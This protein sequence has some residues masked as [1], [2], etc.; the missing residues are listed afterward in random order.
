MIARPLALSLAMVAALAA[1]NR[2]PEPDAVHAPELPARAITIFTPKTELFAEHEALV[3]GQESRFATH[4]TDLR[5]WSAVKAGHV[6]AVLTAPDGREEVFSVDAPARAGIFQPV[7]KPQAAGEYRLRFR[8]NAPGLTDAIDA[9]PATVYADAQAA[10]AAAPEEAEDPNEIS[11]LKEQQ[12]KIPFMTRPVAEG[13]LDAGVTL[14]GSV[15]P[16][17]GKEVAIAAPAAG[18]VALGAGRQPQLGATVRAGELLAVLTPTGAGGEDRATLQGAVRAAQATSAQARLDLARAQ[19]LHA[20]QAAP[21]K[22]VEEARTALAIAEAELAAARE[23]LGERT[24]SLGG[25]AVVTGE[26]YRLTAPIGGTIVEAKLVPGAHVEPGAPLYRIVDLRTVWVEARVPEADLHR[27]AGAR[28]AEI[29]VPGAPP[30]AVGPGRGRLVTVGAVLDP[31]TRTAPAIFAVP[32]PAG[33]LRIG[34]TA[35]VRALTGTT[36]RGPVIPREAVVDDNG[37][38]IAYVQ[39]GGES[40]ERRELKLGVKQGDRVQV[41]AGLAP[42]DRVVTRGGYEIRLATLS[43]AVPAHG[44][45]H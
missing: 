40:F 4:L 16:A 3:V 5:D 44:H 45:E 29:Q 22:R 20:A 17:G 37:R 35:E 18:R 27:V 36:P 6:D 31:A 9:G 19:R 41:L 30:V 32:N 26:S 34:M 23:R 33:S 12:W 39:T 43:N 24:A 13:S 21:R 42:G 11:F 10:I 38:P 1:C 15:K 8:L 25:R 7:V 2:A 14:P 28:R